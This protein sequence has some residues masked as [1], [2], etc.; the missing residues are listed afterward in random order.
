MPGAPPGRRGPAP[1]RSAGRG[2][3]RLSRCWRSR[4]PFTS[5]PDE[6]K[7]KNKVFPL[8]PSCPF[9]FFFS[10]SSS[11]GFRPLDVSGHR[12]RRRAPGGPGPAPGSRRAASGLQPPREAGRRAGSGVWRTAAGAELRGR[13]GAAPAAGWLLEG[14]GGGT[15][16][17]LRCCPPPRRWR[18][19]ALAAA[20]RARTFLA[21]RA[22]RAGSLHRARGPGRRERAGV[23]W[24]AANLPPAGPRQSCLSRGQGGAWDREGRGGGKAM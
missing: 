4:L 23:P 8:P 6:N 7:G 3:A 1:R 10:S 12:R 5:A 11:S 22:A 18:P 24:A 13:L 17:G 14:P 20:G 19:S 15:G 9:F 2:R 16:P 21:R